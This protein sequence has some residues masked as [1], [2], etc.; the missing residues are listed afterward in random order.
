MAAARAKEAAEVEAAA[1][2]KSYSDMTKAELLELAKEMG[3][4]L[5][6]IDAKTKKSELIELLETQ[7]KAKTNE[8]E[9]GEGES[10][11]NEAKEP[12][13]EP[14]ENKGGD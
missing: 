8:P 10:D 14:A 7:D 1:K 11:T 3:I 2:P 5:E 12:T 4:E 13:G 9:S 6:T